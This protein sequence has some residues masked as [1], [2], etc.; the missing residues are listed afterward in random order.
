MPQIIGT[1]DLIINGQLFEVKSIDG[2]HRIEA[3]TQNMRQMGR[4]FA[5]AAYLWPRLYSNQATRYHKR[6]LKQWRNR[7]ESR[8]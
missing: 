1:L 4:T 3:L 2:F 7:H 5:Q 8:R 6:L